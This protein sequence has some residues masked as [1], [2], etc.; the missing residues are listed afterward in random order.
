M[1]VITVTERDRVGKGRFEVA[2]QFEGGGEHLTEVADPLAIDRNSE[3]LLTW[4]F[5]EH[6]RYPFLDR[7]KERAAVELLASYGREL[8]AQLFEG[9]NDCAYEFQRY[10]DQAFD[11]LRLEIVGGV[12]FHRIHWESL[13]SKEAG[14]PFGVRVPIFRRVENVAAGFDIPHGGPT[15]NV[16]AVTARPNGA[17]DVGYRTIS[18]PLL[19]GLRQARVPVRLD[20]VR[21]GSWQALRD[22]LQATTARRGSGWYGIVH[23]D[24][25]G[26]VAAIDEMEGDARANYLLAEGVSGPGEEGAYLFFETPEVGVAE[27]AS[28]AKVA[29]LLVEHRVPVAV[30]NAC[31]SAMQSEGSEASL[32]QLLVESGVPVALGMA[33]SVTVSAAE[34]M[35]PVVY[36]QLAEGAEILPAI[37]AGRR[38]LFDVRGRRAYFDREVDLEDW[39]LPVAFSQ[40]P[41]KL[42]PQ[43]PTLEQLDDLYGR[44]A[45]H[46]DEPEPEYGFVGRDLDV[47][48]IE[49][50][51]LSEGA[52]SELLVSG[53]AGA[54]KST[55]L[56]HLGWWWQATGLVERVFDFSY[57]ERAWT[58]DQILQQVIGDLLSGSE[59]ALARALS[60]EA[61]LERV[62]ALLAADRHLL[63][64][65]NAESITAAPASI[66]H[67]LPEEQR[68][69]LGRFLSRLRG[70]K[71]LV[72]IGS[73][74]PERWLAASSFGSNVYELGGLD[75]QA[76][77]VL[78]ERIISRQGGRLP[79]S[80]EE[81]KALDDL[82]DVLRGSPLALSVVL[83]VVAKSSPSTVLA[84]LRRGGRPPIPKASSKERSS[85]V[86][87]G[88]I[89]RPRTHSSS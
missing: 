34:L 4:Y 30:L 85:S 32:A 52:N 67:S 49:R 23:F 81:R 45:W 17:R 24:V 48:A 76:A 83:P 18:R 3:R 21:P 22:H 40:R 13:R 88:S 66:P 20:L 25:H 53:M 11:G 43:S 56:K 6:L 8:F 58:V 19:E 59:E 51:L 10:R 2:I 27:P 26:A 37:H 68:A 31:Q 46:V 55:L 73:R 12:D 33:Y 62:A 60:T 69:R 74:G 89:Q 82:V 29:D 63:I 64:L 84:E 70:G 72:L 42:Q 44:R 75:P 15:L 65:D 35:M 7:D 47:Q 41:V 38:K 36:K 57:E 14:A 79:D 61:Q 71:T 16:L 54:G 1:T 78:Q 5:E 77:S 80:S 86:T 39:I 50:R 9:G 28:T 87:V